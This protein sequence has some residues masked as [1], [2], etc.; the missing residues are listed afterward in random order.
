LLSSIVDIVPARLS[1]I[2]DSYLNA[3]NHALISKRISPAISAFSYFS[4]F[5]YLMARSLL[6][7]QA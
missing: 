2:R 3:G 4:P 7:G 5:Y 1:T 6:Y